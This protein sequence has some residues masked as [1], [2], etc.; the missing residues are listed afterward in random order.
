M[1]SVRKVPGLIPQ[2]SKQE[3]KKQGSAKT[4]TRNLK[5]DRRDDRFSLKK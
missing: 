5:T 2:T 4:E 1:P 3:E